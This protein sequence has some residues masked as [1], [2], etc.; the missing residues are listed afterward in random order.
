M[1]H[2]LSVDV[3]EWFHPE[4]VNHLFPEKEWD[5][6]DS[7]VVDN[8]ERLLELFNEKKTRA[9]FFILGWVA[10]KHPGLVCKIHDAGHEVASHS[11]RHR[12]ITQL[13]ESEYRRD[14]LESK[15][16]L[17]DIIGEEVIGFRA[18]TFSIVKET[19]WAHEVLLEAGFRY[20][21]SIYPIWHDRYGIPEA[22][23]G[24]YVCLDKDGRRLIEFP[25]PTLKVLGKNIPF[26]GGGY[27]RILPGWLTTAAI[28]RSEKLKRPVISYMHP[29]EFDSGQ[30][31]LSLGKIQ[32]WRHYFNINKNFAK[33]SDLL[34][35]FEWT[36]FKSVINQTDY[37][38]NLLN[39]TKHLSKNIRY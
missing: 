17:E 27:L 4:A 22:P 32:T 24:P 25:M 31:R 18:P 39:L 13:N 9:T 3:E 6:L 14:L 36:N 33:L 5:N 7:R 30:P 20:D 16:I 11:T 28:R 8:T 23:S 21:S 19:I 38:E 29:W 34:T 35:R 26:G 1:K 37:L 10:R 15:K 2:I 12:M